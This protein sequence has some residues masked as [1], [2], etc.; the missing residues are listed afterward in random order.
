MSELSPGELREFVSLK[1]TFL[2]STSQIIFGARICFAAKSPGQ[3]KNKDRTRQLLNEHKVTMQIS[4]SSTRSGKVVTAGYIL[5]KAARTTHRTRFLQSLRLKLPKETPFF[6]ILQFQRTPME[7]KIT[8]LVVQCGEN[9]VSPLSKALSE[10]LTGHN[11]SLYLPRLALSQ[12]SSAQ[13]SSYFEMQDKYSKSLKSLALLPTLTNLDRPRKEYG[14][15]GTFVERST[16]EW[17]E[18]LITDRADVS[19]RCEVVNGGFNQKAYLLLPAQHWIVAQEHLRQYR[20]RI[21]PIGRREARFRDS[22]PGLPS[23][24]HIDTSTQQN[25]DLLANMSSIDVWKNAPH[26]IQNELSNGPHDHQKP[27]ENSASQQ[28]RTPFPQYGHKRAGTSRNY[29]HSARKR[30]RTWRKNKM[31]KQHLRS[32]QLNQWPPLHNYPLRLHGD[33]MN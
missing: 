27:H 32:L 2:P 6:D 23:V 15:D 19:A 25:L 9:H 22:L 30:N 11:S 7:Q 3:W 18:S 14:E 1:V 33:L 31:I 26:T 24:I 4:N 16:R 13:I 12:L 28:Q 21:N 29:L 5:F 8:H 17:A 10:I 20:L